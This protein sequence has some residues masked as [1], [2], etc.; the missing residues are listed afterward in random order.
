MSEIEFCA[1]AAKVRLCL[2]GTDQHSLAVKKIWENKARKKKL[3]LNGVQ[4]PSHLSSQLGAGHFQFVI[5]PL[6]GGHMKW[7]IIWNLLKMLF[8]SSDIWISYIHFISSPC[9]GILRT[10]KWPAP[11]WH[12]S[13]VGKNAASVS[14]R[15]WVPTPLKPKFFFGLYF[16]NCLSWVHNCNDL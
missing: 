12:D 7:M 4:T 2:T 14:P 11:S 10:H 9:M 3:G 1:L 16:L 6:D 8:H 5:I 15:S 13:S